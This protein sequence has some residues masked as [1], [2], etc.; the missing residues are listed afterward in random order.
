MDFFLPTSNTIIE[1]NGQ[2]HY[3][4]ID[5][6]GGQER[7]ERQEE[8]DNAVRQYCKEHKI[9]LIEIPYTEYD[10]IET[11]LKKELNIK[12]HVLL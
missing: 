7:F 10:D 8:R 9:K 12:K 3:E 4:A 2:Q 5:Y 11:I 6:F 1:Y